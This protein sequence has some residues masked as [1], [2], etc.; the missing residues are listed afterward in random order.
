MAVSARIK[1]AASAA[2]RNQ[3]DFE[4][5]PMVEWKWTRNEVQPEDILDAARAIAVTTTRITIDLTSDWV[6]ARRYLEWATA[7]LSH[8]GEQAWDSA[9]GW[10]KRAVCRQMD[11]ILAHNHLGRF[12]GQNYKKKAEYLTR[13]KVPGLS[14]LRDLVIDPR[15]DIEHAYALATEEQARRACELAELF[16]GATEPAV[17]LPAIAALGWSID[18]SGAFCSKPGKEYER[19]DFTV[20]HHHGPTLLI[21]G[22]AKVAEVFVLHPKDEA[23]SICPRDSFSSDQ[24][25]ELNG[26]LRQ[27]L[28]STSYSSRHFDRA[29]MKTLRG[30]LGL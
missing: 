5:R 19:H 2:L 10:A 1:L 3:G 7:T 27:C 14:L 4:R 12:L 26:R 28:A 20:K 18:Y 6:K 11:G 8:G 16:L 9:A 30:Q 23:L 21:D 24:M 29:L 17:S 25:I 13:L 15:N 22:Y